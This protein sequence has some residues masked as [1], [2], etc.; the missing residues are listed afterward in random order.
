MI[1]LLAQTMRRRQIAILWLMVLSAFWGSSADAAVA[2]VLEGVHLSAAPASIELRFD[3]AVEWRVYQTGSH[4]VLIAL[5]DV[6][7]AR[8]LVRSGSGKPLIRKMVFQRKAEG[9]ATITVETTRP[10]ATVGSRW[11]QGIRILEIL[12]EPEL[13]IAHKSPRVGGKRRGNIMAAAPSSAIKPAG[14]TSPRSKGDAPVITASD[15]MTGSGGGGVETLLD[16]IAAS[17]C[18]EL[19]HIRVAIRLCRENRF[20]EALETIAAGE[21]S[22]SGEECKDSFHYL[23]AWCGMQETSPEDSQSLLD[24]TRKLEAE[25]AAH[26]DSAFLPWG[27]AMMGHLYMLLE[28]DPF[29]DGYFRLVEKL[30]PDFPGMAETLLHLGEIG[31]RGDRLEEA[32]ET[33]RQVVNRYGATS[34]GFD[35]RLALGRV[36]FR[37]KRYFDTLRLLEPIQK[38]KPDLVYSEQDLLILIGNSHY[39]TGGH[40]KARNALSRAY[41][42]FPERDDRDILLTRV[43]ES[44]GAQG[45]KEKADQLYR[46][47]MELYPGT[48]G[49]VVSSMRLTENMDDR[50]EREVIYQM[51]IEDYPDHPLARLAMMR[52]AQSQQ[53]SGLFV[54]SIATIKRLLGE[55]P[56]ALRKDALF[57]MEESLFAVLGQAL[58]QGRYPEVVTRF[59]ADRRYIKE[60]ESPRIHAQVADAFL[61]GHLY[62]QALAQYEAAELLL[63]GAKVPLDVRFGHGVSAHETGAL[64]GAMEQLHAFMAVAGKDPRR[65]E[66]LRRMAEIHL[67]QGREDA[68][69]AAYAKAAD[70]AVTPARKG[71]Y[72][73]AAARVHR[74]AGRPA[75]E[76]K[77]LEAA[78]DSIAGDEN[79]EDFV[80]FGLFRELAESKSGRS[81]YAEAAKVYGQA[82]GVGVGNPERIQV[83]YRLAESLEQAGEMASARKVYEELIATEDPLWGNLARERLAGLSIDRTLKNS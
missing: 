15:I 70:L 31:L 32:E 38:E 8:E 22:L 59:K 26:P 11:R 36:M 35:A 19:M 29:A 51:V 60:F 23:S 49:F 3:R 50:E 71:A 54:E 47:V 30:W 12:M 2:P 61:A 76:E 10:V 34:Y 18:G 25:I 77:L 43:A 72:L 80:R 52:L 63:G 24:L 5:K 37:K 64:N 28:N 33:L 20:S 83:R 40:E 17:P 73:H 6:H 21:S 44:Y 42:Y 58:D 57:L 14:K 46:L 16:A 82:Y 7:L 9:P 68:G 1:R 67:A 81:L 53:E 4:E 75:A 65:G 56:R 48:D 74:E 55:D 13:V 78:I 66:A 45:Y 79:T 39:H 27:Y 69:L 41:N 62:E